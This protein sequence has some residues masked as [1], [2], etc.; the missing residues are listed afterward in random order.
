MDINWIAIASAI[1]GGGIL[2]NLYSSFWGERI[3]YK[4]D[5]QKWK[6]MERYKTYTELIDITST[7]NPECGFDNLPSKIRSLSQKVYLLHKNG[8]P[9]QTLCDSLEDIFQLANK[10]KNKEIDI[11]QFKIELRP[12]GSK[13]RRELAQS[14]ENA[15]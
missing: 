3:T 1:L 9:P 6:R 13:L 14:L 10:K 15:D 7:S 8:R 5:L 4:R 11:E 2:N 12:I